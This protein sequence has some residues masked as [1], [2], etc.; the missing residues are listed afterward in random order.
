VTIFVP[1]AR[2]ASR[3]AVP[4]DADGL[5]IFATSGV[6]GVDGFGRRDGRREADMAR[7]RC[8]ADAAGVPCG[9]SCQEV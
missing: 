6:R 2:F 3:R 9:D 1:F 5:D 4:D 7:G 8:N